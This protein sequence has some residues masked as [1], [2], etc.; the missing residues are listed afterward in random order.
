MK[1]NDELKI[2]DLLGKVLGQEE[3]LA[4]KTATIGTLIQRLQEC[5]NTIDE[6][7]YK[8]EVKQALIDTLKADLEDKTAK[9]SMWYDLQL[10][11][12]RAAMLEDKVRDLEKTLKSRV[13]Y[14]DELEKGNR[15]LKKQYDAILDEICKGPEKII[16]PVICPLMKDSIR[17]WCYGKE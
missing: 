1:K 12:A 14:A 8:V 5:R 10:N 4:E 17:E 13:E 3:K 16:P 7:E 6:L 11:K 15:E 2:K 9:G